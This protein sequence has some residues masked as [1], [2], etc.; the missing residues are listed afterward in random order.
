MPRSPRSSSPPARR[1][2]SAPRSSDSCSPPS[3]SASRARRSTR[4]SSS[5]A[6]TSS[7]CQVTQCHKGFRCASPPA[8]SGSAGPARRFA[9]GSPRSETTWTQPSSSSRTGRSSR[10]RRSSGC[11]TPGARRGA[12]WPPPTRE[13]VDIPSS[14]A[15]KTGMRSR[16][17]GCTSGR[18]ASSPATISVRRGTSTPRMSSLRGGVEAA[19]L[20]ELRHEAGGHA[21]DGAQLHVAAQRLFEAIAAAAVVA[22]L[23][24]R[25]GLPPTP[26]SSA[27][28]RGTPG[29][30]P[31]TCHSRHRS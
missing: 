12:S 4:S 27:S 28:G 22:P 14:W 15:E 20:L 9:A 31:R 2:A 3:S 18:C 6:R 26:R 29:G 10:P 5:R 16:T 19:K 11:S 21:L 24:V 1:P 17:V 7:N 13:P 8:P 25:L 30:S 23:E